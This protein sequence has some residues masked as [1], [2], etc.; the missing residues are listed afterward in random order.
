MRV[1]A[2]LGAFAS[3]STDVRRNHYPVLIEPDDRIYLAGE[4]TTFLTGWMAGAFEAARLVVARLHERVQRERY[5]S[6]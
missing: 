2:S 5:P 4:H 6:G 1:A 3:Y